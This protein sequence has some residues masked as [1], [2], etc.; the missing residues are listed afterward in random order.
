MEERW[1][2]I[3]SGAES[4]D[5]NMAVDRALLESAEQEGSAPIL[6]FYSW[7]RST[8]T[9]GHLQKTAEIIDTDY[10]NVND[11]PLVRRPTG[12]RAILHDDEVTYSVIVPE[13]SQLYRPLRPMFRIISSVLR[14]ALSGCGVA[15]DPEGGA[16]GGQSL[17]TPC[18]FASRSS[19]EI[20]SGGRKI[21]GSAQR[22]LKSTALQQG[23]II[24]SM[25]KERYLSCFRW[26]DN[27]QREAARNLMGGI[28]RG[29]NEKIGPDDLRGSIVRAFEMLYGM[30]FYSDKLSDMEN[31]QI[32]FNIE[33]GV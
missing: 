5:W 14:V 21:A 18:C 10:L 1:R 16:D 2:L 7:E 32:A 13:D 19:F 28:N 33:Q 22:R 24:L 31:E 17:S 30:T 11:I 8:L 4:G 12:G 9:V 26:Q 3:E 29:R 23:S 20:S 25:D 15:I 6:R 27:E